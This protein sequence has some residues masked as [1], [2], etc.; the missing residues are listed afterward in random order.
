MAGSA[1]QF[2]GAVVSGKNSHSEDIPEGVF[3]SVSQAIL[4]NGKE[5]QPTILYVQPT[6]EDKK[7]PKVAIAYLAPGKTDFYKVDLSFS[8]SDAPIEFTTE[9]PGE[10]HL[11]GFAAA[12]RSPFD[13][14]DDSFSYGLE[15]E[16][17]E[18]DG[19][20]ADEQ[21]EQR[22]K[23]LAQKRGKVED[24]D[25][26]DEDEDEDEDEEEEA[27]KIGK[28]GPQKRPNNTNGAQPAKKAKTE[29]GKPQGNATPAQAS[30][31]EQKPQTPKPE[32]KPQGQA[33]PKA[34]T[35]KPEAKPQGQAPKAQ[36]PKPEAKP[37]GQATPKAQTPKA[38][39]KPQ[40]QAAKGGQTPKDTKAH[41]PS[42]GQIMCSDCN[43]PFPNE[44]SLQQHQEQKHKK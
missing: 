7:G 41:T 16:S 23:A 27:P 28:G 1:T 35:P 20:E 3:V 22:L 33:T 6:D 26:E 13:E 21:I 30:K 14:D 32:A 38:D 15:G 12:E 36:T 9:G 43:R 4:R 2:W 29:G 17:S 34:Q 25:E 24:E 8:S 40:A 42:K 18:E 11:S 5:G 39:T 19:D 37:Q 44:R 10:V 31:T